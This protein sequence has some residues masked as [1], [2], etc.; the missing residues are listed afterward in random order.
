MAS[1]HAEPWGIFTMAWTPLL[2]P[3]LTLCTGGAPMPCPQAQPPQG[4]GLG[5]PPTLSSAQAQPRYQE[6]LG[7]RPW[8]SHPPLLSCL[9]RLRGLL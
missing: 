2:I 3:L 5:L 7:M 8:P 9:Y 6:A 1:Q 4:P